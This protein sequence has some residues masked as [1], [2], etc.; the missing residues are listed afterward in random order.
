MIQ[1][2][3]L[4]NWFKRFNSLDG[5]RM[6]IN[7]MQEKISNTEEK[8]IQQILLVNW[9]KRSNNSF[10]WT[11]WR[12]ETLNK[13]QWLIQ[14]L[15]EMNQNP[16]ESLFLQFPVVTPIVHRNETFHL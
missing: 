1:Q 14:C 12:F 11:D 16:H 2:I 8:V 3:L 7:N 6:V 4:V 10:W 15:T 9:F 5:E 13:A